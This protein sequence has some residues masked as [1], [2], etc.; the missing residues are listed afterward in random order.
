MNVRWV[1]LKTAL[2]FVRLKHRH[3]PKLQGGIVALGLFVEGELRGVAIIGRSVRMAGS[4]TATI[5]RLCTDG[6]RNGC[7]KLYAKAKRLAQALG[8]VGIKTFTR[9]D[10][11]AS[12]L[13][14]VGAVQDGVTAGGHWS[15]ESRPRDIG[16]IEPKRRWTL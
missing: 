11:S 16:D 1:P 2:N 13:F 15:R 7:S 6:C 14:A 12:S 9:L 4:D 8:F 10:E 5:T 3:R